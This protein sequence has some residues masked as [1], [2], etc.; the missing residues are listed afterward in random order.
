MLSQVFN[1]SVQLSQFSAYKHHLQ[2]FLLNDREY[3]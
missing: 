3:K 2:G 1:S